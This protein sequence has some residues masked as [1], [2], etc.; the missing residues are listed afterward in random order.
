MELVV[1][2][3]IEA[4]FIQA[5]TILVAVVLPIIQGQ[6]HPVAVIRAALLQVQATHEV[7][8]IQAAALTTQ[9]PVVHRATL[10]VHQVHMAVRQEVLLPVRV[11]HP[12]A[13]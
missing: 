1:L 5:I 11:I 2:L 12:V 6:V 7:Q 4:E 8:I 13:V 10:V 9:E 3:L